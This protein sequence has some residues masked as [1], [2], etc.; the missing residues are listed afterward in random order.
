MPQ[1]LFNSG[2]AWALGTCYQVWKF[3]YDMK[4]EFAKPEKLP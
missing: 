4:D 1:L 3:P 2:E